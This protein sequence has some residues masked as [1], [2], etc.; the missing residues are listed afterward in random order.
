[1]TKIKLD[2]DKVEQAVEHSSAA[3]PYPRTRI[4]NV[5]EAV[6]DGFGRFFS[7]AWVLLML[8]VVLNV[9]LRYALNKSFVALEE[10]QWHIYAVG[11][12]IG[13]SYCV[14]KDGHVRVDVVAEQFSPKKRATIEFLGT[15]L[16]L[17]PFCLFVLYYAYPFV[18]RSFLINERSANPGGLPMRWIIKSVILVA[19]SLLMMAGIARALR[20]LSLLTGFPRPLP[21]TDQDQR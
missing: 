16:F 17:I 18:E 6:I 13:L 14:L 9:V 12:M 15:I 3:V 10:L 19:F 4:T 5:I 1:M 11:F 2:L 8:L 20:A 7:W 21:E